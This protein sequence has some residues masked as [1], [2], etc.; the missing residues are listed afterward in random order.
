MELDPKRGSH[1]A[2][3]LDALLIGTTTDGCLILERVSGALQVVSI[4]SDMLCQLLF[5][6]TERD[7]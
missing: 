3:W 1:G 2:I 5:V 6:F 4:L 7:L